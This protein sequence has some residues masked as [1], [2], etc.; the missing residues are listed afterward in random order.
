MNPR[1]FWTLTALIVVAVATRVLP[2]DWNVASLTAVA[3]FGGATFERRRD[4]ALVP[5]LALLLSD[6]L[7]EIG[8]LAG[9]QPNWGFYR[10][11]WVV[12]ACSL[13][14]VGLG[15]LIR[16]RRTVPMIAGA[17]LAGSVL[18]FL[19]TNLAFVYGPYSIHPHT[20][21]GVLEGYVAA[22][23]FFRRSLLGDAFFVTVLFGAFALAEARFP[24]LRPASRLAVA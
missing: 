19:V 10:G 4:A 9:W 15:L 6:T 23:P 14:V 2:H 20:L 3:L 13:A 7:L 24:A 1:R 8:Y 22:L 5:L 16:R 12:Y 17:T 21:A 18:F 11:Q